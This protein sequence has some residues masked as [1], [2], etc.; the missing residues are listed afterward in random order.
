MAGVEIELGRRLEDLLAHAR[1]RGRAAEFRL[2][3]L[4]QRGRACKV[5]Y[6][7][8]SR[9]TGPA[10]ETVGYKHA[11]LFPVEVVPKDPSRPV[12]ARA[13]WSSALPR[14]LHPGGGQ[15]RADLAARRMPASRRRACWPRSTGCRGRRPPSREDPQ[16]TRATA[17][18]EGGQP[19]SRRSS[20]R[21]PRGDVSAADL[22]IEAPD[23]LVRS[24]GEA[25]PTDGAGGELASKPIRRRPRALQGRPFAHRQRRRV[26]GQDAAVD[27]RQR[28]RSRRVQ[29]D[30][31]VARGPRPEE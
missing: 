28:C 13:D 21:F 30:C 16:V 8:P 5:L 27:A 14:D 31:A 3:G 25:M 26:P 7:A 6:P 1:R 12:G 15:V 22:F 10:A 4:D 23:G 19:S 20:A 9:M 17:F 18:L 11:V 29:L 24:D 2:V